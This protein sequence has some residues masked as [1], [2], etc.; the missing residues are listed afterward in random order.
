MIGHRLRE[1]GLNAPR[2]S[3]PESSYRL[4]NGVLEGKWADT[5][6]GIAPA[7]CVC[8]QGSW[9]KMTRKPVLRVLA[10]RGQKEVLC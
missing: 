1:E 8:P 6:S 9:I 2:G 5:R 10:G 4:S 3:D 7:L